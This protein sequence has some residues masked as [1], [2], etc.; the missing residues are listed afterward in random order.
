[1]VKSQPGQFAR[2]Y[3][4]IIK[5]I[6]LPVTEAND[7]KSYEEDRH[8]ERTTSDSSA[9]LPLPNPNVERKKRDLP[10]APQRAAF[11]EKQSI[12]RLRGFLGLNTND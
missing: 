2:L 1:M 6:S 4:R 8:G 7:L 10:G 5:E 11:R 12:R 9:S 3:A